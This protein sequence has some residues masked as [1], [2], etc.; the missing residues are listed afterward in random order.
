MIQHLSLL[1]LI[2]STTY[3]CYITT[4]S[5]QEVL[6]ISEQVP[7]QK[8]PTKI[9]VQDLSQKQSKPATP[10][11]ATPEQATPEPAT[12]EQATPEQATPEQDNPGQ[13]VIP[14]KKYKHSV[15]KN[16]N[17]TKSLQEAQQKSTKELA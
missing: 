11:Q 1:L 2:S 8:K 14:V 15:Q 5:Y 12:P 7:K 9:S 3:T 16:I 10:E 13:V 17:N 6:F 4:W